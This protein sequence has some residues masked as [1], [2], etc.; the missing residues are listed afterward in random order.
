MLRSMASSPAA[1][2]AALRSRATTTEV[3]NE[4]EADEIGRRQ[5][6]DQMNDET[7]EGIDVV[8]GSEIADLEDHPDDKARHRR[9]LRDMAREADKLRG[10]ADLKLQGL[11]NILKP[12]LRDGYSP[13]VFCRFIPTVEY[14]QEELRTSLRGVEIGGVTGLLPPAERERRV[15]QLAESERRVLV[16]TDCL[17]EGINLQH[18]FDAVVHYDL[19]WN[20]TR[21]EQREGRVDRYGQPNERV[22]VVTYY[23]IDN[24][25]DGIVLNVLLRK[26]KSI[27][28]SLGISVSIPGNS[29]DV[30]EAIF[31][32]L[33]LRE[34]ASFYQSSLPGF[35]QYFRPQKLELDLKWE[36]VA[37]RERQSRTM[38][39]QRA[40]S[41]EDVAAELRA[42]RQAVG[43]GVDV[44]GF[45]RDAVRMHK[46]TVSESGAVK[47]DLSESPRGLRDVLGDTTFNVRYKAPVKHDE[48]LLTRTHPLVENLA[49]YV[50]NTAL[51]T[52]DTGDDD[53][54]R[55]RRAGVIRTKAVQGRTTL[56]LLRLRC[57]L[58]TRIG[59]K[60]RQL[61]AEDS[62]T[63]VFS[64][65]L[66]A[67]RWLSAEAAEALLEATPG[68]NVHPQEATRFLQGVI[69]DF[70]MIAPQLNDLAERR[71]E[72]LRDAHKRVRQAA[73]R[74][75]ERR[76]QHRVEPQ[77]P[78]D[79]LGI[80]V[81]LPVPG[82]Q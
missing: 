52:L 29:E 48:Q 82:G 57:H 67:P 66:Q 19:S 20:P 80:F 3:D 61:L 26:H 78:P 2:A 60:E 5:V 12:L 8:P 14:L 76:P 63:L 81:Y 33:L 43:S 24:Q 58:I 49:N 10:E 22:K 41:V 46:G 40:I 11:I 27:R 23:G 70:D 38:F 74:S 13:I 35:E 15:A 31:E 73:Y 7:A 45:V 69:A 1:A 21:H 53:Q 55:A 25:I 42:A 17:S 47:L 77:L 68:A 56:L 36:A 44:E 59:D 18:G 62:L 64:G 51:D 71:G 39:A 37:E 50:K 16:C 6:L 54:P 79:V 34:N 72:E 4:A 9:R 75:D 28:T 30:I 65:S 32:G